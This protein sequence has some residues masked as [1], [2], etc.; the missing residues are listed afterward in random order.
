MRYS[1]DL[2]N[3]GVKPQINGADYLQAHIPQ[4]TGLG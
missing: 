1:L 3:G 4:E 2:V